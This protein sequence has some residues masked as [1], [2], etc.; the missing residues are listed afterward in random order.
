MDEDFDHLRTAARATL[1]RQDL[2][3]LSTLLLD[4]DP[5][6]IVRLLE[7]EPHAGDRAVLY[8]LLDRQKALEVFELLEPGLRGELLKGLRDEDVTRLAE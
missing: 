5:L 7:Q 8:R 1:H 3:S 4:H 2:P 6:E